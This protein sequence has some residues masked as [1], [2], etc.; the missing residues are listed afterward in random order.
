VVENGSLEGEGRSV[1]ADDL[2]VLGVN[3]DEPFRG[4]KETVEEALVS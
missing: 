2:L 1:F 3:G 4:F